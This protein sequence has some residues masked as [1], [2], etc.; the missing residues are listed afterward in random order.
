M[1]GYAAW[2]GADRSLSLAVRGGVKLR[3]RGG[4][5]RWPGFGYR[6]LTPKSELAYLRG[7][8]RP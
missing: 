5:Y 1:R 8:G 2:A 3:S 7:R 6:F 4:G